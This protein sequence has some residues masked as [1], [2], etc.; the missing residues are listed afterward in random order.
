VIFVC[1]TK[2]QLSPLLA[3][4]RA[5]LFGQPPLAFLDWISCFEWSEQTNKP[6]FDFLTP[7]LS[8]HSQWFLDYIQLIDFP[9]K[10]FP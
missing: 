6:D 9:G 4:E 7:F 1:K 3:K 5:D 8:L 2:L 10:T